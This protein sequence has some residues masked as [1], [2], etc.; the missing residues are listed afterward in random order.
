M[1]YTVLLTKEQPGQFL[2]VAVNFPHC[3]VQANTRDEAL[4]DI[5]D[6]LNRF[7]SQ[8]EMVQLEIPSTLSPNSPRLEETPWQWFGAFQEDPTWG[9]LFEEI[10]RQR[11]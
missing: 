2:A 9:P 10:E 6:R 11:G 7:L 5:R 4:N 3:Q 8:T 1:K